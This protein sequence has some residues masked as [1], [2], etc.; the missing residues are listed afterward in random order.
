MSEKCSGNKV[1]KDIKSCGSNPAENCS[2]EYEFSRTEM[3]LGKDSLLKLKN[4]CVAVFGAGGVGGGVI[5]ALARGGVGSIDVIDGDT[6]SI[7]NLN[8]QLLATHATLGMNKVDAA[9]ERI[10]IINPSASVSTYPMLYTP[11]SAADFDLSK[12]DYIVDAIDMVTA[13]LE[14]IER[15]NMCEIP[16]ISSMGTGNKLNPE[17]FEITDIN[18]TSVCPLARVMRR[19]LKK[20]GIQKLKVLYSKEEPLKPVAACNKESSQN[21]ASYTKQ[22]PGS[23]SFVPPVAG[24][25]IGGE[26]IKD[27]LKNTVTK[28]TE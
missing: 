10:L 15:A 26:V 25:M 24:F 23:V 14:L 11:E 22:T 17:M 3:I 19:E 27:L 9:K 28:R 16:I 5:E 6:I 4:S 1:N 2:D 21:P 13:K 20:K 7:S 18:K 12:Y 8:R